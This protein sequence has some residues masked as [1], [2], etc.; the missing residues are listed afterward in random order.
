M[1]LMYRL[2]LSL[3]HIFEITEGEYDTALL[4]NDVIKLIE[5][6]AKQKNIEFILDISEK[7]PSGLYGDNVRIHQILVNVLNNAVKYTNEG[8]VTFLI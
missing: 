7:L 6:K 5:E 2:H 8:R 3:I 1:L 4:L